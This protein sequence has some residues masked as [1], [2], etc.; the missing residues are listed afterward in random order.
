MPI[1]SQSANLGY[2]LDFANNL[3]PYIV[4]TWTS[5]YFD[6]LSGGF[7]AAW[8]SYL[9]TNT[10]PSGCSITYTFS[11]ATLANLSDATPYTNNLASL[12]G[13]YIS[14]QITA[15]RDDSASNICLI[16]DVTINP[17]SAG[18]GMLIEEGI[19]N[20][21]QYSHQFDNAW[22]TKSGTS[23]LPTVAIGP[24]GVADAYKVYEDA[25]SGAHEVSKLNVL[26]VGQPGTLSVYAKAGERSILRMSIGSGSSYFDLANGTLLSNL[27]GANQIP[28]IKSV[29][30]GWYRC[31][32]SQTSMP[33]G[34]CFIAIAATDAIGSYAGA[35]GNGLY[36]WGAQAEAKAYPT[37]IQTTLGS[38]SARAGDIIKCVLPAKISNSSFTVAL[39]LIVQNDPAI[40]AF[41]AHLFKAS[42]AGTPT[43]W[44]AITTLTGNG[45]LRARISSAGTEY[46]TST[47][48]D[49]AVSAGQLVRVVMTY[50]GNKIRLWLNGL[51]VAGSNATSP[52]P[53]GTFTELDFGCDELGAKQMNALYR[54]IAVMNTVM[55]PA[56]CI[57]LTSGP[58]NLPNQPGLFAIDFTSGINFRNL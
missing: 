40:M 34:H 41:N 23:V 54:T 53:V 52:P 38:T 16:D 11:V 15:V 22:W 5:P 27:A 26:T 18:R 30:N 32:I 12:T 7:T 51:E 8:S 44:I 9:A 42:I 13:R 39:E 36:L 45:R 21:I 49:A 33:T 20:L 19:T 2:G 3:N 14:V 6:T 10:I 50:N 47:L 29:G 56:D 25:S 17:V 1:A 48:S 4:G 37:S 58:M 24:F 46:Y 28:L 43:D 31:S 55:A 57:A 35:T